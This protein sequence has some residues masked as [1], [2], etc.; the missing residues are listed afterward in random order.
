MKPLFSR[1]NSLIVVAIL[2]WP[3]V[4]S[5]PVEAG[6]IKIAS[7]NVNNLFDAVA[8]G[9]E[10][11]DYDPRGPFGWDSKMAAIKA[12]N[13]AR[14]LTALGADIVCLQEVESRRALDLLLAALRQNGRDYP[15]SAVADEADTAVRC[16]VISTCPILEKRE[17]SPG[18]DM[19]GILRVT[20]RA[21]RYPLVLFV[22]HWKSKQGP[23]SL[24]LLYAGA[25]KAAISRLEPG[26]D[27]IIA[28]D[29]NAD[30]NE[31]VTFRHNPRLNDTGGRT[32]INHILGT[33]TGN[34][35]VTEKDLGQSTGSDRHYNLWLE[36]P[37]GRR[38]SYN[39]FGRKSGLDSIIL[40]AALYDDKGIS[41]IDDSFDRFMPDFLFDPNGA[42]YRWQQAGHGRGRHLGRGYSD[43]LPVFALFT[44][45]PPPSNQREQ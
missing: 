7:Y 21:G 30:Y 29:F 20:V 27:Y 41:Y 33:V 37:P 13:I 1:K 2:F 34:R 43:H 40:P 18:R 11:P 16:A 28:G 12:A 5:L 39:F 8:D 25:L 4:F 14:V 35:L 26:T 10:Y 36:L 9:T 3:A 15:F 24:C 31:Y 38:W 44:T 19:R 23:E 32:G 42:V 22:N 6:T 45:G 17:I